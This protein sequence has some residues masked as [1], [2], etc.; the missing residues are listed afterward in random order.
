MAEGELILRPDVEHG[1]DTILEPAQKL[2]ARH[3]LQRIAIGE[4]AAHDPFDLGR[5][6]LGDTPQS[7]GQVQ[8]GIVGQTVEDELAV[9]PRG[10]QP[11]APHVPPVLRRVCDGQLQ[12]VG[13]HLDAAL[14]LRQLL[15]QLEAM[16]VAAALATTANWPN[17]TCLGLSLDI[18][19]VKA[20]L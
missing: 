6:R 1:D 11:A 8:H 13:Q 20:R 3:R 17:R 19:P 14:A 9:T 12:P 7:R 4:V 10:N 15:Q 2:G 18:D 5:L 16:G